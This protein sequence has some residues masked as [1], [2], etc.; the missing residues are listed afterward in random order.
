MTFNRMNRFGRLR[1]NLFRV[2]HYESNQTITLKSLYGYAVF[3]Y[4]RLCISNLPT[5]HEFTD[6]LM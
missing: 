2:R 4:V 6:M 3:T 5:H 1:D